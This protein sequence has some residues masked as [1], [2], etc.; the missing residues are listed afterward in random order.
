MDGK[1][2]YG[3]KDL[4]S[5]LAAGEK[6]ITLCAGIYFVIF[7]IGQRMISV[8]RRQRLLLAQHRDFY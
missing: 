7:R 8:G 3:Q 5:A 4:E 6:R 2:V 1:I